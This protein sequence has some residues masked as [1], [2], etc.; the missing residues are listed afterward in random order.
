MLHLK[1][2]FIDISDIVKQI[3]ERDF[4]SWID[5]LKFKHIFFAWVSIVIV[6]GFLY[7]IV[8]NGNSAYLF[9]NVKRVPVDNIIDSI[10]F[11][12]VVATTTGF[13]DIV[14]IGILRAISISEV[15]C[16]LILLACITSKIV[17]IKQDVILNE[18]YE[19]SFTEKLNRL[20]SSLLLFRQNLSRVIARVEEGAM[21]SREIKDVYM[22]IASLEDTMNEIRTILARQTTS[23]FT[24]KL[25]PVDSELIFNSV[26]SSLDKLGEFLTVANEHKLDWRRDVTLDLISR[27]L[28]LDEKLF[29]HLNSSKGL[30]EKTVAHL[31][32]RNSEVVKVVRNEMKAPVIEKP[33]EPVITV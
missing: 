21:K 20:R 3:K 7:Y 15:L 32:S 14:P 13:G 31:N 10:Y 16:C 2:D 33:L 11:S 23:R 12:F 19:M 29:E 6:F 5:R 30:L 18:L 8:A 22:Y 26:I 25:D 4:K 24:K 27:C 1:N 9:N 17:S 28:V